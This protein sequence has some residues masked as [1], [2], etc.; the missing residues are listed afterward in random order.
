MPTIQKVLSSGGSVILLSHLGR[1]KNGPEADF[2]LRPI[3][4][5]IEEL[6]ETTVLFCSDCI[7]EEAQKMS[8]ALKPGQILLLENVRFYSEETDGDVGFAKKLSSLGDCYINDAFGTAHRAHAS[9]T[10]IT[11]NHQY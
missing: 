10:E 2:S 5:S 1:P 3:I 8:A 7:S 4:K 9:T 6:C 11:V